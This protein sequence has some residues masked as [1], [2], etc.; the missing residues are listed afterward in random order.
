MPEQVVTVSS[1]NTLPSKIEVTKTTKS[2][3]W[4]ISI[5]GA[6]GKELEIIDRI[7]AINRELISRFK[8]E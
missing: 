7:D 1:E 3:T 8:P 5:R 2:Y 4:V 6:D